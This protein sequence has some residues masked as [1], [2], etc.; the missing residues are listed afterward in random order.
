MQVGVDLWLWSDGSSLDDYLNHSCEPN[1]GFPTG[2]PELFALRDIVVGEEITWDY[3]TS[4]VEEGWNLQCRCGTKSCRGN[5]LPFF[6]LSP[7][8]RR[9]LLPVSL[10]FIRRMEEERRAGRLE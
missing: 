5:I 4:L 2:K 6:S 8:D 7:E 9:R 10:D 3:S 1:A